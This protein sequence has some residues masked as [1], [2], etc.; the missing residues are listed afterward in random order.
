MYTDMCTLV[1]TSVYISLV[2]IQMG[3][4]QCLLILVYPGTVRILTVHIP[5]VLILNECESSWL[6][7]PLVVCN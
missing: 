1:H 4:L 5:L 3:M 2:C 6:A 7:S